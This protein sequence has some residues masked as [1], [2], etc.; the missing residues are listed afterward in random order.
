MTITKDTSEFGDVKGTQEDNVK[1][2]V[3]ENVTFSDDA[4][5]FFP[6]REDLTLNGSIASLGINFQ[7]R[8]NEPSGD[9]IFIWAEALQLTETNFRVIGKLRDAF[10]NWKDG[11]TS[12]GEL[13]EKLKKAYENH[14]LQ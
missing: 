4:L 3:G 5:K 9:G 10:L 14:K 12:D 6:S 7:F 1:K 2:T 8:Y 11:I 13:L